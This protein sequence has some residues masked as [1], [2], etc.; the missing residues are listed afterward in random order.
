MPCRVISDD[1]LGEEYNFI[2]S[3]HP[4]LERFFFWR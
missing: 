4:S 1:N 3:N 2:F